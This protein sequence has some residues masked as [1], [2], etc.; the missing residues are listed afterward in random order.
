M[1]VGRDGHTAT[2]LADGRV[3]VA[4]GLSNADASHPLSSAELYDAKTGTFNSTGSMSVP[5]SLHTATLLQDGRV[6]IVGGYDAD[7]FTGTGE[8][9]GPGQSIPSTKPGPPDPRRIAELY[10]PATGTFSR[11]GTMA[12]DRYGDTATLLRDGRVLIVGG[13]SLRSGIVAST[14][15]Y[16]PKTGVFTST[17]SMSTPR[18]GH[19]ATLLPDGDVLI[20]GGYDSAGFSLASAELYDPTTGRFRPA[21]SMSVVRTNHTATLVRDGRVLI[22]GGFDVNGDPQNAYPSPY[23]SAELYDPASGTFSPTGSMWRPRAGHTATLLGDG[24]VLLTGST[25]GSGTDKAGIMAELYD[26]TTGSFSPTEG[27]IDVNDTATGL[28]DGRVLLTGGGIAVVGGAESLAA[29]EL[30]L[31]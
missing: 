29:A 18:T 15:L 5:R 17:G 4:G 25:I 16:D 11:T 21:G 26:P 13:E 9:P 24:Q 19:T 27:M 1:S 2:L 31:P 12:F 10:D 20:A 23:S 14:E 28:L 8:A 6:L 7:D 30:Y 22:A 3:L